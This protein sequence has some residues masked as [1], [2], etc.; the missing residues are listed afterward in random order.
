MLVDLLGFVFP[1]EWLVALGIVFGV[2]IFTIV[3]LVLKR[4][5][6]SP[7]DRRMA[8]EIP[9]DEAGVIQRGRILRNVQRTERELVLTDPDWLDDEGNQFQATIPIERKIP[10]PVQ[11]EDGA[12]VELWVVRDQGDLEAVSA[13]QLMGNVPSRYDVL[14]ASPKKLFE[15]LM[16]PW[17][18]HGSIEEIVSNKNFWAILIPTIIAC[19]AVGHII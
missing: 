7:I 11:D 5:K 19:L 17:G 15:P 10:F 9:I 2:L 16:P 6:P 13:S 4:P 1:L 8:L 18:R 12:N 3:F 14:P